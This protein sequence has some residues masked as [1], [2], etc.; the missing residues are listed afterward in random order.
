MKLSKATNHFLTY[1]QH[2]KQLSRHTLRAYEIDLNDFMKFVGPRKS[3]K[4]CDK[5]LI[6]EFIQ[7][8]YERGLSKASVKRRIACLKVMFR[9]LEID[10]VIAENP[11][12]KLNVQIQLPSRLPNNINDT[13]LKTLFITMR[14]QIGLP[15]NSKYTKAQLDQVSDSHPINDISTLLAMELLFSTGIRVSELTQIS[16]DDISIKESSIFI[17]GKGDKERYVFL[18][19]RAI[20]NLV[21]FYIER[22]LQ[23]SPS[24]GY[25]FVNKLGS[26]LSPQMIRL[27]FSRLATKAKL[28]KNITP[29]MFRHTTA[30]KLLE[31][32]VDI[33]YVQKL[34][35][36]QDISTTQIYT[37][38]SKS[39]LRL[40]IQGS[41]L[42]A[43]TF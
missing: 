12:H 43:V 8:L 19:D 25:L 27:F 9:W 38:V 31:N 16:L 34:L 32:D 23:V 36:H 28:G 35:G 18:P 29:H 30:S 5:F 7:H 33:R 6:R 10:E 13:D 1:C 14:R 26:P 2:N 21:N 39:N 22:R 37:H 17:H 42:R 4:N 41:G 11:F 15:A 3:I 20:K 24:H 40:K